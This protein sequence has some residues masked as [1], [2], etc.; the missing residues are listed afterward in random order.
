MTAIDETWDP[1][2]G[3]A[4]LVEFEPGCEGEMQGH[5]M[6]PWVNGLE[7]IITSLNAPLTRGI[8][9]FVVAFTS[10]DPPQKFQYFAFHE[11]RLVAR[12]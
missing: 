1:K 9:P 11:L 3:D 4:V 5:G 7:G 12:K 2:L 10:P 8:H 6:A